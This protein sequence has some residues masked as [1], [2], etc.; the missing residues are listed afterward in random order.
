MID[1][2]KIF[3]LFSSEDKVKETQ[4]NLKRLKDDPYTKLGM[5]TKLIQNHNVFHQK[6]EKFLS[7]ENPNFD[8]GMT[9]KASEFTVFNRAYNYISKLDP[10]NSEVI[11]IIK[12]FNPLILQKSITIVMNY[13]IETEEYEKCAHLR[14]FEEILEEN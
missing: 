6:L 5:F 3:S 7:Q 12:T 8:I 4:V 2:N 1:K 13:F 11:S 14:K 9:K 10:K